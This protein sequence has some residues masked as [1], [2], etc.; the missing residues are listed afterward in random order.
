MT[1]IPLVLDG[2]N[3]SVVMGRDEFHVEHDP[4]LI[5]DLDR[6]QFAV[7][8]PSPVSNVSYDLRVGSDYRDHR[9]AGRTKLDDNAE[10]VILPHNAVIIETRERVHFPRSR[11]GVIVPKVG[12]LQEG[13]SNTTS[14][15][16]PGYNGRLLI[17]VF[18]LGQKK[19]TL[20]AGQ[21]FCTLYVLAVAQ[22]AQLYQK[23]EKRIDDRTSRRH[24]RRWVD[25]IEGHSAVITIIT[26]VLIA[27]LNGYVLWRTSARPESHV[28][29]QH[30]GALSSKPGP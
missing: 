23:S 12:L 5:E 26:G 8:S 9:D 21:P 16:D 19:V 15:I 18:N 3:P 4:I 2:A 17:T 10:I 24:W 30:V 27:L 25:W 1:V 22:G 14:K 6:T 20:K 13:I 11:F 29:Q 28:S 7:D